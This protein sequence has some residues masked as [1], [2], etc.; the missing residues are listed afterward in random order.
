MEKKLSYITGPALPDKLPSITSSFLATVRKTPDNLA[1][2]SP[3]QPHDLY[4][5]PSQPLQ[6]QKTGGI[7]DD[8]TDDKTKIDCSS[9]PDPL[10]QSRPWL[11]WTYRTL[12]HAAE[13]FSAGLE[14]RGVRPGTP[15]ITFLDSGVE[16]WMCVWACHLKG[17]TWAPLNPGNLR[18]KPEVTYMLQTVLDFSRKQG[19][20]AAVV[21]VEN[22]EV[23]AR[24]DALGVLNSSAVRLIAGT[25]DDVDNGARKSGWVA[26]NTILSRKRARWDPEAEMPSK[27]RVKWD[28]D[29]KVHRNRECDLCEAHVPPAAEAVGEIIFFTSGSTAMPKGCLW[30]HPRPAMAALRTMPQYSRRRRHTAPEDVSCSGTTKGHSAEDD[31]RVYQPLPNNHAAAYVIVLPWIISG[32]AIVLPSRPRQAGAPS[33]AL[34]TSAF[35]PEVMLGDMRLESCTDVLTVPTMVQA[36]VAANKTMKA[37]LS[38]TSIMMVGAPAT[39][40]HLAQCF[41]ELGVAR[42]VNSWGMSECMQ[43][44][45]AVITRDEYERKSGNS[46]GSAS[47]ASSFLHGGV[48][49]TIG[50]VAHGQN[51]KICQY[52]SIEP[53]SLSSS[54]ELHISSPT[55]A[56]EYLGAEA[57]NDGFYTDKAGVQWFNTGDEALIDA[58]GQIFITGR[59]KEVIVRGGKNISPAAIESAI[60][61]N[62]ELSKL[63]I[64][65]VGAPDSIAGQVPVVVVK[66]KEILSASTVAMVHQT[67]LTEMGPIYIPAEVLALGSLGLPDWPRTTIGKIQRNQIAALVKVFLERQEDEPV[68]VES[69]SKMLADTLLNHVK[70][71]WACAVGTTPD[72]LPM[73]EPIKFFSDSITLMRVRSTILRVT[74]V[75]LTLAEMAGAGTIGCQLELLLARSGEPKALESPKAI[76]PVA[77][78]PHLPEKGL[79]VSEDQKQ[80]IEKSL[81]DMDLGWDD[82]ENLIAPPDMSEILSRYSDFNGWAASQILIAPGKQDISFLKSCLKRLFKAHPLL[83]SHYARTG[84]QQAFHVLLK[85]EDHVFDKFIRQGESLPSKRDLLEIPKKKSAF[86]GPT[87]IPGLVT[88]AEMFEIQESKCIAL[89]LTVNHVVIDATYMQMIMNDLDAILN[90]DERLGVY[91]GFD[92]WTEAYHSHRASPEAESVSDW[93]VSKLRDLHLYEDSIWPLP[94][95]VEDRH[96]DFFQHKFDFSQIASFRRAHPE[97]APSTLFK[98]AMVLATAATIGTKHVVFSACE[99]ARERMPF[100]SRTKDP[101]AACEAVDVAGPTYGV[102]FETAAVRG[103]DSVLQMLQDLQQHQRELT[104][105]ATACWHEICSRLADEGPNG[106]AS[107]EAIRKLTFALAFNWIPDIGDGH[108]VSNVAD[109]TTLDTYRSMQLLESY[110]SSVGGLEVLCSLT[111]LNQAQAVIQLS[112]TGLEVDGMREFASKMEV[113]LR[114]ICLEKSCNVPVQE[115]LDI[116]E[117]SLP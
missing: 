61:R 53:V 70:R 115:M 40:V 1:L 8:A 10:Y 20:H 11:R 79:H 97:I 35:D 7:N 86:H 56:P 106:Q 102:V 3:S 45:P 85:P 117:K 66:Q 31:T 26:V 105:N 107:V 23:A 37:D 84:A 41:F 50:T 30:Q 74:G 5:L 103:A 80:A 32:G 92:V 49:L 48:N 27:K 82:C 100:S 15:V 114:S 112:G 99:S 12:H 98:A 65:V 38:G 18:N 60:S 110:F 43:L 88:C 17:Y 22:A 28:S 113:V 42:V 89:I 47:R 44:R 96:Q 9:E 77:G 90:G 57:S 19:G 69:M 68:A 29:A 2:S 63:D 111:G 62:P 108:S 13:L 58:S 109:D 83:L 6:R 25:A 14:R 101:R 59:H 24:V 104:E 52:E 46:D 75:A 55:P 33:K 72:K 94:R 78:A 91:V 93:H 67:V 4:G 71:I 73:D 36:L 34:M 76:S 87:S 51:V 39:D 116:V 64:L 21:F 81:Q 54:G 16:S 95:P